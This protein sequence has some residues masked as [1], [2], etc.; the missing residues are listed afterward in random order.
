MQITRETDYAIRC[1]YY[2]ALNR[3]KVAMVD[4]ISRATSAPKSFVAKILQK[5]TKGGFV[6]SYRG[7]KGGFMLSRPPR[8]ITFLDVIGAVQG[9]VAMNVCALDK[10]LCSRSDSCSIHPVWIEIRREVED[11]LKKKNFGD[12]VQ[13]HP[14]IPDQPL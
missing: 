2:L 11:I 8:E 10:K 9:P 4:E 3:D 5:L 7:V 6:K 13:K 12:F 1:V 14:K